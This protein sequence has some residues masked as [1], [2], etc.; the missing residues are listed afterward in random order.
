MSLGNISGMNSSPRP[1]DI[2]ELETS[3]RTGGAE[4]CPCRENCNECEREIDHLQAQL[5]KL[6]RM[7]FGSRSESLPPYRAQ[8]EAD[9]N[10]LQK[11]SD[12]LTGRVDDPAVQ[13]TLRQIRTANRS[14]NHS[15]AMKK[16]AASGFLLPE[17][18]CAEL[19]VRMPLNSWS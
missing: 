19:S 4:S 10:R 9:L 17:W 8:M 13:R 18:W 11:E 2:D 6:R 7:N 12:T 16:P 5:D 3:R 1:D 15:P 14:P